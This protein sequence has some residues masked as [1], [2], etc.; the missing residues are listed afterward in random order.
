MKHRV[1]QNPKPPG[2]QIRLGMCVKRQ[3]APWQ[4]RIDIVEQ[5]Q[6]ASEVMGAAVNK[7]DAMELV[8]SAEL[9]DLFSEYY[10]SDKIDMD[11]LTNDKSCN[12]DIDFEHAAFTN[13]GVAAAVPTNTRAE[14]G[15]NTEDYDIDNMISYD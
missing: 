5:L 6:G 2:Y 8:S 15:S 7:N 10:E 9:V 1:Q 11:F 4:S 3:K 13:P 12:G 14:L